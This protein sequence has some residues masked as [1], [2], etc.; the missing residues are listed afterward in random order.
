[1]ADTT[2]SNYSFVKPEVGA[3]ED[4][5]GG[6]LN[7][8]WDDLDAL[9]GGTTV[10]TGI[11]MDDTLSVVDDADNSKVAQ[12]QVSGI[13]TSTTRTFT[14]P[15]ASGTLSLTSDVLD[16]DDMATDSA[17]RPPSQQSV[18]AYVAPY[19]DGE[20]ALTGVTTADFTSIPSGTNE[21][22]V[23]I[24]SASRPSGSLF[25][26]QIGTGGTP[27]IS[28]YNATYGNVTIATGFLVA[29]AASSESCT[30]VA[31]LARVPGTNKWL[32]TYD[33][34]RDGT[35]TQDQARGFVTL[36]GELDNIRFNGP[37]DAGGWSIR[38]WK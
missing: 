8:N 9:L 34:F 31:R 5:W 20:D 2:T 29:N 13:T 33:G 4:T 37:F 11:K 18:K 14:F 35:V 6:K 3:S 23:M 15:D 32:F 7:G 27:T 17:T 1:M 24:S 19:E 16:E 10:V 36:S 25:V 22:V 28:G 26:I 38:C 12:F 30:G 21:I